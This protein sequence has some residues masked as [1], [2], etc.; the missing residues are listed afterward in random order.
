M[1]ATHTLE[2]L[3]TLKDLARYLARS[4]RW[5]SN[6]LRRQ[7]AELG[8]IPHRRL[9]GGAP[10]FEPEEIREWVK[11]GCPPIAQFRDW[12]KRKSVERN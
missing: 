3:W 5:V 12:Q 9:P 8:S 1:D 4:E 6:A 10:R 2:S 7:E 11:Q